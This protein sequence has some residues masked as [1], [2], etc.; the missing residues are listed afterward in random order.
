M[1]TNESDNESIFPREEREDSPNPYLDF[2]AFL[3]SNSMNSENDK[4]SQKSENENENDNSNDFTTAITKEKTNNNLGN[5]RKRYEEDKEIKDL[6]EIKKIPNIFEEG[7]KNEDLNE[8]ETIFKIFDDQRIKDEKLCE[9]SQD[10]ED[11]FKTIE[12]KKTQKKFISKMSDLISQKNNQKVRFD[13]TVKKV[14]KLF[15]HHI[16]KISNEILEKKGILKKFRIPSHDFTKNVTI[17][18]NKFILTIDIKSLFCSTFKNNSPIGDVLKKKIE[19]NKSIFKNYSFLEKEYSH[20]FCSPL[21]NLLNDY[22][23]SHEFIE[24][25]R[26]VNAKCKKNPILLDR[27]IGEG[28]NNLINYFKFNNRYGKK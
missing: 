9:S 15:F 27:I 7:K 12:K 23:H 14:K 8:E 3:D 20:I 19:D 26:N 16:L 21:E 17:E 24:D 2:F 13:G 6:N 11:I 25:V 10:E 4:M 1:F 22:L 5:K 18:S 28:E